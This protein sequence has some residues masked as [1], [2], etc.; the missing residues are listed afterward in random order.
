MVS[1]LV[2]STSIFIPRLNTDSAVRANYHPR[3]KRKVR[4]RVWGRV[5]VR[6]GIRVRVRDKVR[7]RVRVGG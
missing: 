5:R 7:V 6:V 1:S 4:V 3:F 2:Q